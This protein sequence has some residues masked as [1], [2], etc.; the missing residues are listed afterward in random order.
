MPFGRVFHGCSSSTEIRAA[1][2]NGVIKMNI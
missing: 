1:V 2:D